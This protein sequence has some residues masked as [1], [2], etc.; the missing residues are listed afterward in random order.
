MTL[1]RI[2]LATRT[3]GETNS[4]QA[5]KV[6]KPVMTRHPALTRHGGRKVEIEAILER[7]N[8]AEVSV[9]VDEE[10]RL[11]IGK[12]AAPELKA[13]VREHKQALTEWRR[14]LNFMNAAGIRTIRLPLGHFALAYPL[15][16]DLEELRQAATVLGKENLPLVVSDE[17]LRSISWSEW[18][19]RQPLWTKRE[20]DEYLRQREVEQA[21]PARGRR[22]VA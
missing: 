17:N 20:R 1:F 11:R 12:E 16:T 10:G 21:Q 2:F 14:A 6:R 22:K 19:L 15:G 9:W 18:V 5:K 3:Y 8:S 7:L 13:L 4:V